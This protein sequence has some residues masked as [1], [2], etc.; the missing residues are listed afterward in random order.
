M[1]FSNLIAIVE[2]ATIRGAK[3]VA[4]GAANA[5]RAAE[6]VN[7]E[8]KAMKLAREMTKDLVTPEEQR[9]RLLIQARAE[10]IAAERRAAAVPAALAPH[11]KV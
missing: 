5:A 10:E 8:R 4:R 1:R 6:R 11:D 2:D 3:H 9:E 7:L